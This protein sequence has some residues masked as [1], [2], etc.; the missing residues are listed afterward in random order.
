MSS[1]CNEC[2][3]GT[4]G[5]CMTYDIERGKSCPCR[6]CLVKC[7]C[8]EMCGDYIVYTAKAVC[9]EYDKEKREATMETNCEGCHIVTP[10]SKSYCCYSKIKGC[11]CA[12]CLVKMVC[13]N[14][15]SDLAA[16]WNKIVGHEKLTKGDLYA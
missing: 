6:N 13:R 1:D 15:C 9:E 10:K 2:G 3:I 4:A 12:S 16:H 11:P 5:H 7:M 8:S 14:G